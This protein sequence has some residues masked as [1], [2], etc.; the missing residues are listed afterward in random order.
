[1]LGL[2]GTGG[3]TSLHT[4][5]NH[6]QGIGDVMALT[7]LPGAAKAQGK[8]LSIYSA[9][10][11]F[12]PLM[13]FVP[14]YQNKTNAFCVSAAELNAHYDLGCGHFFQRLQR[15]YGLLPN[16]KPMG[17]LVTQ[18][19]R[20]AGRVILHLDAG[21]HAEWQRQH[22]HPRAREVYKEN[23]TILQQF[24]S[25]NRSRYEFVDVGRVRAPLQ[26]VTSGFNDDIREVV[27]IMS[28]ATHFIGI[29]S[30]PMHMATAL[31]LNCTIILNF[32][33]PNLIFLPVMRNIDQIESE[34]LYGQNVHLHQDGEGPLVPA[35]TLRNLERAFHNE[36]YPFGSDAHLSLIN[37]AL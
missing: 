17:T 32:P 37:C 12:R 23:L 26:G 3:L 6:P 21:I 16:L 24:I 10:R 4:L 15:A 7:H 1:V 34:W 8:D 13:E 33:D 18:N 36:I 29:V 19:P 27:D 35:F 25:Q 5:I 14:A 11:F 22:V 20:H 2:S 30:G 31:G 9:S 28:T